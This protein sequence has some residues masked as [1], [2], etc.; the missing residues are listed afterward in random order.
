MRSR[1]AWSAAT[2]QAALD[3]VDAQGRPGLDGRVDRAEVPLVGRQLAV[4]VHV[5]LAGQ[6]QQLVP[7]RS[8]GR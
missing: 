1:N 8:R 2:G 3:L 7:W 5:P 4:G 6:E